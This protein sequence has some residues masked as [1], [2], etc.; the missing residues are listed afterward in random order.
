MKNI[1]NFSIFLCLLVLAIILQII[2]G[3]L[4]RITGSGL[5]CPDWPLCYGLWFPSRE[6]IDLI[7]GVNFSYFQILLEWIHR[8]NTAL[9]IVPLTFILF[10]KSIFQISLKY[11]KKLMFIIFSLV[12]IQ[13]LIGGLTV[14]DKNSPWSVVLHL[15]LALIFLFLTIRIFIFSINFKVVF[16][17]EIS[18]KNIFWLISSL[19]IVFITMVLGAVVSKSGASLACSNWPLCNNNL[20][21]SSLDFYMI[22]HT[23][24]RLFA[25]LSV[26]SISFFSI[27]QNPI[28]VSFIKYLSRLPLILVVIQIFIG[29]FVIFSAVNFLTSMIHQFTAMVLFIAL[30]VLLSLN[31]CTF[32]QQKT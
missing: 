2:L 26:L 13:S 23:S 30:S 5:S 32:N 19:I 24:H 15:S 3:T 28:K 16:F 12:L 14:I 18:N 9:I 4:V 25:I 17:D 21:P 10:I 27:Y 22:I 6:K 29:G 20:L 7:E 31:L 1:S 8:L 11:F